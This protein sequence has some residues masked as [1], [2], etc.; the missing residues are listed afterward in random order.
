[1]KRVD[2]S[3][4]FFYIYGMGLDS[5]APT[6]VIFLDIDG[7][8]A[9]DSKQSLY[10]PKDSDKWIKKYDCYPFDPACV[11]VFNEILNNV[12]AD[13]VISSDWQKFYT[14]EQ[15]GD[16]F[17]LNGIK[18]KPVDITRQ[19]KV[20]LSSTNMWDRI[21]AIKKYVDEHPTIQK[22]VVI[23]DM[24][25]LNDFDPKVFAWCRDGIKGIVLDGIKDQI[26][27]TLNY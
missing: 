9:T 13:I 4:L 2:Y 16:I 22:Y 23:D 1:M 12:E 27:Y 21:V 8:L 14:L 10:T 19:V 17:E 26:I 18:Q 20:K 6:K 15:L 25:M 11:E 7:V 3:T 5:V 24:P